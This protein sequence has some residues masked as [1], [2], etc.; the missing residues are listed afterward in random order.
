MKSLSELTSKKQKKSQSWG[1]PSGRVMDSPRKSA[2][3][4]S[5]VAQ[6]SQSSDVV[7]LYQNLLKL[8]RLRDSN[9]GELVKAISYGLKLNAPD[10]SHKEKATQISFYH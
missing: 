3:W 6:S 1:R 8:L 7:T 9:N 10:F 4:S 5:A 2:T